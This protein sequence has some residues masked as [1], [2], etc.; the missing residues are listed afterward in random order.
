MKYSIEIGKIVEGA[1]K[2]DKTKVVNYTQKLIEKLEEDKEER[3]AKKFA[4]LLDMNE[5]KTLSPLVGSSLPNLPIDE[6][7]R[8]TL[9]DII[10]PDENIIEVIL[11]Q[12]N[13]KKLNSFILNYVNADKLNSL[14]LGVAN[15]LLLYGPPG[16]GKTQSAFL[17]ARELKLP[18][19]IARLDS[20]IS[21]YLG[22]TSKNIRT[23]F[24]FVQKMPC[25]LFLDEF[26]ALAKARDDSNELGELKRVVN[27][28]LQNIDSMAS[29]SL[30][31][32]ATNHERLLDPA[33]WR[34][35]DYKLEIE[36]P[37][38]KAI[39][40]LIE[41]FVKDNLHL[42]GK[43]KEELASVFYGLSGADIEE[44]INKATRDSVIYNKPLN[45]EKIYDEFFTF[46]EIIPQSCDDRRLQEKIKALYL[47]KCDEKVFSYSVI[48]DILK[49]SKTKVGNLISEEVTNE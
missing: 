44:I 19:V 18:L 34:R 3:A 49:I 39:I 1:L 12:S 14:G 4:K 43:D 46:K 5:Q 40:S 15:T 8:S 17:I 37:D 20:M 26:D 22:T 9:V 23:L 36:L 45:K 41:L 29:D 38:K 11:S 25:V 7:S 16:C 35:F 48:A 31:L 32:A 21:S 2:H 28:L 6:E 10:Y 33:V 24:E 47:R 13:Y 27:S 42:N 30:L